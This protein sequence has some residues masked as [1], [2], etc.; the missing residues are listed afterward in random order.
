M[1]AWYYSAGPEQH[2]PVGDDEVRTLIRD[3]KIADETVVWREG[4]EERRVA[5]SHPELAEVFATLPE[6]PGA[7]E[8]G[9][10]PVAVLPRPAVSYRPWPRFW[11]RFIDNFL[12][13]PLL[14]AGIGLWAVFYA[15]STYLRMVSM[16]SVLLG[17][18]LLPLVAVVLAISMAVTGTTPGKAI[19][20]VRVPVPPGRDRFAFF[21]VR[22]FMVWVAGLGFGIPFVSL[23]TQIRQHRRVALGQ[24]ASYD[25]GNPAVLADPSEVR[26]GVALAVSAALF[27]GTSVL[28]ME[29]RQMERNLRTTQSWSNPV[30]QRA[31][32][33]GASWQ[34][35]ELEVEDGRAFY[36][37]SAEL[38]SEAVFGHEQLP[39]E[40]VETA[41]YAEA[42]AFALASDIEITSAWQP[43]TVLDM[44]ALQ[45]TGKALGVE[46]TR[47]EVTVAVSGR[48]A[49]RT[50]VYTR[51]SSGEQQAEAKRFVD[52]M[53]ATAPK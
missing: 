33:I 9:A 6:Q 44:T 46:D 37:F 10:E 12:F 13:V 23:F 24:P 43:V 25:D 16:P 41:V 53:F 39:S 7:L 21:L 19:V 50:L 4:A 40:G 2:G 22:E 48:D 49:W 51:G 34:P 17:L 42:L 32:T 8:P 31:A 28:G 5:A 14:G 38:L 35:E 45:A 11:A 30:T 20:G 18:M 27:V 52:A 15:P 36:F 26:F 1:A 3:G 29:D 47:V